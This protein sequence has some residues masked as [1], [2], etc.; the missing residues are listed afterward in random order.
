MFVSQKRLEAFDYPASIT[1]AHGAPD[2][3]ITG[4]LDQLMG[5]VHGQHQDGDCRSDFVYRLRSL[6][7][8][9]PRHQKIEHDDVGSH[10]LKLVQ[11]VLTA[12]RF[13]ANGP[14]L[15]LLQHVAQP[16]AHQGTVVNN[17]NSSCAWF[18]QESHPYEAVDPTR[19]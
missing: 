9:H 10:L 8:I 3:H 7:A 5:K 19:T 12:R 6:Q 18:S 16:P 11:S 1:L 4:L 13:A 17:K 14:G 15:M 2:A